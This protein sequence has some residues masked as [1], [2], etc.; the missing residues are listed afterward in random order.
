MVGLYAPVG[1][2]TVIIGGNATV[3]PVRASLV[4]RAERGGE[5]RPI[6]HCFFCLFVCL[7]VFILVV[8]FFLPLSWGLGTRLG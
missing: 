2:S 6:F 7:F 4:P 8:F 1:D 5:K 3:G